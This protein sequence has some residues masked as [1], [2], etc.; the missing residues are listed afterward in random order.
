VVRPKGEVVHRCQNK[1]CGSIHRQRIIHFVS[2][3]GFDI[4][5]L[6]P[7]IVNQLMDEGLISDPVDLFSLTRGDLVPLE[8]FAEKSADNLIESIEQSKKISLAKFI[9]ALGIRHVGEET[10]IT[11]AQY[12]GSLEKISKANL[13][14][15]S[16]V[17]DIG[18]V[19]AKSIFEWFNSKKNQEL[20]NKLIKS[21]IEISKVKTFKKKLAGLTFVLTGE[22]D[23]FT[24]EQAKTRIRML[25]GDVPNSVSKRTDFV[26]IGK[27]PGSKYDRAKKIGVKIINEKEFLKML[28]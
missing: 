3:K 1:R 4:N 12:F 25:G 2:K 28:G 19:V 23:K 14:E 15:L 10:A 20:L 22:L 18:E 27:E 17:E 24:R 16:K 9:F 7:K 6:G 8:R 5:G 26:V 11:L 13:E 21:G